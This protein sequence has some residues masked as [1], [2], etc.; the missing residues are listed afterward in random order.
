MPTT[1]RDQLVSELARLSPDWHAHGLFSQRA[2]EA[3]TLYAGADLAHTLETGA[4]RSTLLISNLSRDHTV[5]TVGD[6]SLEATLSS[7]LLN[8][9]VVTVVEGPTQVTLP[10]HTFSAPVDLAL[11]DGPHAYPFPDLEYYYVYPHL[12]HGALLVLDDIHIPTVNNLFRFVREDD[13]F[14]LVEVVGT[15]AFL[16]RT[17]APTFPN[18]GDGWEN[19][20]YNLDRFPLSGWPVWGSVRPRARNLV[21]MP[22]RRMVRRA[23]PKSLRRWMIS[24]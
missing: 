15:T 23:V 10:R 3:L 24:P 21:P 22:I 11:L 2:I 13:M 12:A 9:E 1:E 6:D 4:G 16:R 19:Q 14:E 20:H 7:A 5:F 18:S 17:N 8:H